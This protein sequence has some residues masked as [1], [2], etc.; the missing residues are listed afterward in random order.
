L[1]L[2]TGRDT[3]MLNN[4]LL[5][6][7]WFCSGQSN[8]AFPLKNSV[9]G[10]DEIKRAGSNTRL[11]L[12][13][14]KQLRD[15]DNSAWDS[16]SLVKTNQLQY[17]EGRWVQSDS[18]N[19]AEFSAIAYYFGEKIVLEE[20]VPI[21]LIQ[22]AVGG[23]PIES[24]IDRYSLEHN[25]KVVDLLTN[26]RKSDFIMPWVRERADVNL[27]QATNP[28][29][30]H[31]YDPCYNFEAGVEAFTKFAIKGV[32]W[33][34]GESNAHNIELY[35]VLFPAMVNS[36]RKKWGYNFP[37][38]FVQLSGLDRPS[39]PA[40]RDAQNRLQKMISNSGMAI[41]MDM[42]D[43]LNVHPVHKK[44]VADRLARLALHY[45]YKKLIIA[46]GPVASS[47]RRQQNSVVVSFSFAKQLS[48][49]D[50]KALTGFELVNEKGIRMETIATIYKNKVLLNIPP[51]EKIKRILYA[52]KPFTRAN[53]V[54]EAGL[55]VSTFS[56]GL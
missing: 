25:D 33:Y 37:F 55:P 29:Q 15:T 49:S 51:G 41:S 54:N 24:W 43:S 39:W 48:T 56:M 28:K 45:T 35:E 32:I 19:A 5:G 34:Q 40:F 22:V 31:P 14:F 30:R 9:G 8:M 36:W 42:G 38:Y 13:N 47:A 26:W 4:I 18:L 11:R 17:F 46:D 3:M 23:S 27:K 12:F 2:H 16:I 44:E 52:W 53:L 10:A 6:D 7:V 1:V 50:K 20:N 21:G